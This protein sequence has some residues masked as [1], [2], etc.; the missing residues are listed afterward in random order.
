[1]NK[2]LATNLVALLLATAGL[3][4]P[5][6]AG[7][8]LAGAG[9]Y[10]LSGAFTN[11]LAVYMLFERVPGFYG[12]GVVP[13]RFT[14][15]KAGIRELVMEQFFNTRNVEQF[16]HAGETG[17]TRA[18][19]LQDVADRV[20]F[21]RAFDAL[22]EVIMQSPFA[23]MLAMVGGSGALAPLREPFA[24]R[25]REFL[26]QVGEDPDVIGQL[27]QHNREALLARVQVIVDRRLDELTPELVKDI[28]QQMIHKHL[29][30]LV[31]WG[32]VVGGLIGLVV[33]GLR[34]G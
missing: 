34:P 14:E 6:A 13:A 15:F 19:V 10:A 9:L 7:E 21:D 8:L 32:G 22:V 31:V 23:A 5:G 29:G 1:M 3:L 27:V 17:S 2:S 26:L 12:S 30:W 28:V 24:E 11:W 4:L 33:T 18:S 25:M 20:D 16:L